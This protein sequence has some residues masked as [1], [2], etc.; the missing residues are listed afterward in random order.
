MA[1]AQSPLARLPVAARFGIGAALVLIVGVAY[2]LIFYTEVD[3]KIEAAKRQQNQ[4][5]TE[6]SNQQRAQAD[7]FKDRDELI[8]HQQQQRELNKQLPTDSEPASLLSAIQQ[9]AHL[10]GVDPKA[11]Q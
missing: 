2:W 7:Y 4:L 11:W 6:L 10:P 5:N 8:V 3:G 1:A 9:E